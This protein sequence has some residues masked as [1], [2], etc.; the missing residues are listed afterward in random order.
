MVAAL[1]L[2]W[3]EQ[4]H[5][6]SDDDQSSAARAYLKQGGG[7]FLR[8]WCAAKDREFILTHNGFGLWEGLAPPLSVYPEIHRLF[9]LSPQ[10]AIVLRANHY[11]GHARSDLADFEMERPSRQFAVSGPANPFVMTSSSALP[12]ISRLSAYRAGPGQKDKFTFPMTRLNSRQTDKFNFVLLRNAR[13]DVGGLSFRDA[14]LC[15][16]MIN[17]FCAGAGATYEPGDID[18]ADIVRPLGLRLT[19][20]TDEKN[21]HSPPRSCASCRMPYGCTTVG[22]LPSL[23][24]S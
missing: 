9:V 15:G 6:S 4:S 19:G 3:C 14:R 16:E 23:E 8:I 1:H 24:S 20:M 17:Q 7:F 10:I 22:I 2:P 21:P 18:R 13:P 12:D 5:V 11:D